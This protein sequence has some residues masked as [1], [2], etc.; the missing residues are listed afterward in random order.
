[1]Y[2]R[3]FFDFT[4]NEKQEILQSLGYKIE[5]IEVYSISPFTEFEELNTSSLWVAYHDFEID[6][7]T[8]KNNEKYV[9]QSR[10]GLNEDFEQELKKKI[11]TFIKTCLI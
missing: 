7:N 2:L 5:E 9:V 3:D 4:T 10:I 11:K 1:M 6:I 8:F